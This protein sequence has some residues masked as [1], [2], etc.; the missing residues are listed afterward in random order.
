MS[1]EQFWSSN[2]RIIKVWENAWKQRCEY[3]N[4]YE[5]AVWG[6]YALSAFTTAISQ[7]MQPMLCKG[8]KSR[9]KY[10]KKPI[11]LFEE[12]KA[13]KPTTN[14]QENAANAFVA[15]SYAFMAKHT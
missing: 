3:E 10:A 1:E 2:P 11:E 8:K 12:K 5:H 14:Q 13:D 4:K 7:V 15:W 6:S 9:A